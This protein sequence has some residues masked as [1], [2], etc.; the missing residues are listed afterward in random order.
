MGMFLELD[1]FSLGF[2]MAVVMLAGSNI[3][4]ELLLLGMEINSGWMEGVKLSNPELLKVPSLF[5]MNDFLMVMVT[6][7]GDSIML[8]FKLDFLTKFKRVSLVWLAS[9][10]IS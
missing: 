7:K 4:G 5:L 1:M 9:F 6:E 3:V 8:K 2:I 10:F